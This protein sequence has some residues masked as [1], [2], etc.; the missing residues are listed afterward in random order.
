MSINVGTL[1][2]TVEVLSSGAKKAIAEFAKSTQT[3]E[4]R[5]NQLDVKSKL[6][7]GN[8]AKNSQS[9]VKGV[10]LITAAVG[11]VGTALQTVA[12]K[13]GADFQQRISDISIL[14]NGTQKDFKD[15]G[16]QILGITDRVP[17]EG[18]VLSTSLYDVVSAGIQ[19]TNNQLQVLEESSKLGIAGLGS[20]ASAVDLMTSA[21]N[22]F[23]FEADKSGEVS[24]I[25]FKTV[26]GGKTTIDQLAQSFGQVAPIAKA[27]KVRFDEL[28]AATAALTTSGLQ[29]SVAQ[30]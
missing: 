25:L 12:I 30:T 22:A 3:A 5:I 20:T 2:Y 21:L 16:D 10:S 18:S 29:T 23:Q 14:M 6:S 28:Q 9:V 15:L 8:L 27:T 4:E 1:H 26:K 24:N 13:Q 19:G 11:A 17:V 7:F